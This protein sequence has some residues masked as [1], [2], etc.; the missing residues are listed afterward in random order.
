M[1]LSI[2]K[3]ARPTCL[4]QF[5]GVTQD[6]ISMEVKW[7]CARLMGNGTILPSH[8][9]KKVLFQK[10]PKF[11]CGDLSNN[12][13]FYYYYFTSHFVSNTMRIIFMTL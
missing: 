12:F 7:L 10:N 1:A 8:A 9:I 13:G 2:T 5:S 4:K 11:I 3:M 6:S